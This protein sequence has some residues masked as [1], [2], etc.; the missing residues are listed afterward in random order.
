M[1]DVEDDMRL[2]SAGVIVK[3]ETIIPFAAIPP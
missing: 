3:E 2:L 1:M